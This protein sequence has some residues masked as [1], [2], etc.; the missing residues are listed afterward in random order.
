MKTTTIFKNKLST[1]QYITTNTMT[2][3]YPVRQFNAAI[4][5]L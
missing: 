3:S 5:Y 1:Q 2:P 4:I